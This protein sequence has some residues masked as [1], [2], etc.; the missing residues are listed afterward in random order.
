MKFG[1]LLFLTFCIG[2]F[3]LISF[4][5]WEINPSKWN[6]ELRLFYSLIIIPIFA[7]LSISIIKSKS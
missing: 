1:I 4:G 2:S 7:G 6:I 3:L 5:L